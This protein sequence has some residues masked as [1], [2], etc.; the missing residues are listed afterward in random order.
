[1]LYHWLYT[2]ADQY[3]VFNVFRYITFRTFISFFTALILGLY[4]GPRFI[5]HLVRKQVGQAI[6]SDGPQSHKKKAGTPTMG[7]GLIL[8]SLFI[9]CLLWVD[10]RN[11]LVLAIL[12]VTLGFGGIGYIDDYL[13]VSKKNTKGLPGRVRLLFEFLIS[14]IAIFVLV[15]YN[16]FVVTGVKSASATNVWIPLLKDVY[17]PLGFLY[18]L[19]ASFVIVGCANAVNLTDGLDGLA[20]VP[21]IIS[22][23]T[24][25]IFAYLAGHLRLAQYLSIPY[26]V[27]AGELAP[28][29]SAMVAAGLAFLWFNC[30][31][32][33]VFMGDVGSLSIGGFLGT[34]AVLTKNELL[35]MLV[36]GIFVVVAMSVILQVIYFKISGGKRI[37]RMAPLQHH[38]ELKGM[39]ESKIIVRFWIVSILLAV[40]SLATL[41]LR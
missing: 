28:V 25:I 17:L 19:F 39:E 40:L 31:P 2:H 35:L 11:P 30:Y 23:A 33:Q 7:G 8:L 20:I 21:V 37:F 3:S 15:K 6:R 5:R 18:P 38:F 26:V 22:T 4:I 29:G 1:M 12:F 27:G 16:Y 34:I 13:K 36:G 41:K 9:P 14:G 10:L 24:F 32:A